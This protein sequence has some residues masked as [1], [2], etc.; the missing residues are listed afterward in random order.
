MPKRAKKLCPLCRKIRPCIH[1][2]QRSIKKEQN[3]QK[4]VYYRWYY[5]KTW[6][7][8]RKAQL[9]SNPLC[10]ACAAKGIHALATEVDHI[11][12]HK[13]DVKLFHSRDNLQSLC[14]A[15]HSR[16]TMNEQRDK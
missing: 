9:R 1:D 11:I 14:K 5:Q 8:L 6:C 4:P 16:K 12:P 2:K 10:E 15:C 3:R 7:N 13:G